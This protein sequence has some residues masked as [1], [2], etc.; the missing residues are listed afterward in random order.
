MMQ[1]EDHSC[2]TLNKSFGLIPP[3]PPPTQG[4]RHYI[5]EDTLFMIF[6]KMKTNINMKLI[7]LDFDTD[8]LLSKQ[9]LDNKIL[10][11]YN[12]RYWVC[13]IN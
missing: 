11:Y 5:L 8:T 3:L 9:A 6:L 2:E 10:N 12:N 4:S 13:I 7:N 1:F